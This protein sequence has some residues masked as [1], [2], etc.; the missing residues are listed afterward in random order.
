MSV[1]KVQPCCNEAV[2]FEFSADTTLSFER[3]Q[4][5]TRPTQAC[6]SCGTPKVATAAPFDAHTIGKIRA[7]HHL[8]AKSVGDATTF[9]LPRLSDIAPQSPPDVLRTNAQSRIDDNLDVIKADPQLV[10][11]LHAQLMNKMMLKNS[12]VPRAVD[13]PHLDHMVIIHPGLPLKFVREDKLDPGHVRFAAYVGRAFRCAIETWRD[14][15]EGRDIYRSITA[16]HVDTSNTYHFMHCVVE[17]TSHILTTA[18]V[19]DQSFH[20]ETYRRGQLIAA[21]WAYR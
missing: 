19:V 1:D 8:L 18:Y 2:L 21:P 6:I 17:A 11:E 4:P 5:R 10:D 15:D 16:L 20:I 3:V 9:K 12:L 13:A 14:T 7:Q